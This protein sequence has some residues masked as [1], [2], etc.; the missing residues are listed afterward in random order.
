M[1]INKGKNKMSNKLTGDSAGMSYI[2]SNM[3]NT[4]HADQ[5]IREV[6]K[7]AEEAILRVQKTNPNY[8]GQIVFQ[9]DEEYYKKNFDRIFGKKID[10]KKEEDKRIEDPFKKKV[11][12]EN[13]NKKEI[14]DIEDRNGF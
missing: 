10:T 4:M 2:I 3:K 7:N 13:V 1:Q 14:K 5:Y 9:K 11:K 12:K 8:K 6:N